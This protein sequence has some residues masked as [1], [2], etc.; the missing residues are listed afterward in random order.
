MGSKSSKQNDDGLMIQFP[1]P[2]TI[3]ESITKDYY[4]NYGEANFS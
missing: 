1:Q 2:I 3:T 4:E